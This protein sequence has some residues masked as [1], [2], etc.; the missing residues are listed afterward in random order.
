MVV[1]WI[2][3]ERALFLNL[4]KI[5]LTLLKIYDRVNLYLREVIILSQIIGIHMLAVRREIQFL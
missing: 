4:K 3:T 1:F 5:K 2:Y